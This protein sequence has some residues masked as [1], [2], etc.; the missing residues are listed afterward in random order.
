MASGNENTPDTMSA[1]LAALQARLLGLE[2]ENA[3]MRST[4]TNLQKQLEQM[5]SSSRPHERSVEPN[6]PSLQRDLL[7]AF[8]E[9]VDPNRTPVDLSQRPQSQSIL[10]PEDP[11]Y[12]IITNMR[13]EMEELKE[14][15]KSSL[16]GMRIPIKRSRAGTISD[17]PFLESIT[18]VDLPR[19]FSLPDMKTY[20]GSTDPDDHVIRYKYKMMSMGLA[21]NQWEAG[22]CRGFGETLAGPALTW[23]I[24]LPYRTIGSYQELADKFVEHFAIPVNS[25]KPPTT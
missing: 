23:F 24:N 10:L 6:D 3:A 21:P 14:A 1:Q 8:N 20:D 12:S 9:T 7:G 16:P 4:N 2:E 19:K 17:T 22:M 18:A 11:A 13:R 15:V 5:A 25:K